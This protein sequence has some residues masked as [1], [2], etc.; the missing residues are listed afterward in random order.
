M[1]AGDVTV[2]GHSGRTIRGMKLVW[3]T[4]QLDGSGATP[5]DLAAYGSAV[6]QGFVNHNKATTPGDDPVG[7]TVSW[8]TT[9]LSVWPWKHNGTDP[10][11]VAST[12]N[13]EIIAFLAI[14]TP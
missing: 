2:N 11:L 6:V 5:I 9:I 13:A 8:A 10:T 4:V 12:D 7:F 3:G 14:M 1:A